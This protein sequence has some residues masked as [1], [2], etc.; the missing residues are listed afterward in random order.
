MVFK[1]AIHGRLNQHLHK[2]NILVTE[3]YGVKKGIATEDVAFRLT[4]SAFKSINHKM[5]LG[6]IF[7]DWL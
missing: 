4:Y 3:Q 6:A 7:C 5:R 2:N 1:K